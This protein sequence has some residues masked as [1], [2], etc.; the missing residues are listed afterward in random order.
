MTHIRKKMSLAL[1]MLGVMSVAQADISAGQSY[2]EENGMRIGE[3]IA[4]QPGVVGIGV[5]GQI[6]LNQLAPMLQQGLGSEGVYQ[7]SGR[8]LS[9]KDMIQLQAVPGQTL[10]CS[11]GTCRDLSS[12]WAQDNVIAPIV[13]KDNN[14]LGSWSYA[15]VG[16][17]DVWFGEWHADTKKWWGGV[18]KI[19]GTH[20]VFY[21]GQ[22]GDVVATL[23]RGTVNYTT[24]TI[25]HYN[26]V[27]AWNPKYW[28]TNP[29]LEQSTFVADFNSGTVK[30]AGDLNFRDGSMSIDGN[31]VKL[32]AHNVDVKS[33][34][35]KCG[36]LTGNFFGTGAAS[37]A[38]IVMF[39]DRNQDVAFGG[40]RNTAP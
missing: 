12:Q 16:N 35:G 38:G 26:E 3:T 23:P 9:D 19:E 1:A 30:A 36:E 27:S 31:A 39:P 22:N 6:L 28:F 40:V 13:K 32:A 7:W 37:V 8:K 10:I 18:E 2:I 14:E 15:R 25:S 33:S 21:A 34:H 24:R 29:K 4:K 11:G 17:Q 20:T 5:D